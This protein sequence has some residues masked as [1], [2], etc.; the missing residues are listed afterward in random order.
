MRRRPAARPRVLV[1]ATAAAP[2]APC[3][4]LGAGLRE[5]HVCARLLT[6]PCATP[7]PPISP[8]SQ[9]LP[10]VNLKVPK[11]DLAALR[12]KLPSLPASLRRKPATA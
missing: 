6:P 4:P 2:P 3:A 11:V 12:Q 8:S 7:F 10:K 1:P 9:H 5:L